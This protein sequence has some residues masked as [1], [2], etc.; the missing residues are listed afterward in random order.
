MLR[1]HPRT[2]KPAL[3]RPGCG[4]DGFAV[5][6]FEVDFPSMRGA[7]QN[8]NWKDYGIF[9]KFGTKEAGSL[10]HPRER[11]CASWLAGNHKDACL[12][13]DQD[14]EI[15]FDGVESEH[16]FGFISRFSKQT[17]YLDKPWY[18]AQM[19]REHKV[20]LPDWFRRVRTLSL[21]GV[22]PTAIQ[23]IE[24]EFESFAKKSFTRNGGRY[25][26]GYRGYYHDEDRA[27]YQ[28]KCGMFPVG[29]ITTPA[30]LGHSMLAINLRDPKDRQ[31]YEFW[32]QS[33]HNAVRKREDPMELFQPVFA[34]WGELLEA[35]TAIIDEKEVVPAIR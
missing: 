18:V 1:L 12:W 21:G 26:I 31:I 25:K 6:F 24:Y 34:T 15:R 13:A 28:K 16:Y 27:V 20:Q 7:F 14:K 11:F 29:D 22:R 10:D 9:N 17:F 23:P 3:V 2:F 19:E 32:P 4:H 5:D 33:V 8:P 35:T 30:D